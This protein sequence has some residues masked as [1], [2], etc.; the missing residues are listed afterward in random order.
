MDNS[1]KLNAIV[2][3]KYQNNASKLAAWTVAAHLD[4]APQLKAPQPTG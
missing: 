4:K 2:R 1:R 3:I